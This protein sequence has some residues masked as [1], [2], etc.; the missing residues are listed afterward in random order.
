M[1]VFWEKPEENEKGALVRMEKECQ[2]CGST[3][4]QLG[5]TNI[6]FVAAL[7]SNQRSFY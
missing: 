5:T 7:D 6:E 2:K 4:C 1:K 3:P